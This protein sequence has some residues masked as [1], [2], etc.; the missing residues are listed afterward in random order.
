MLH[1]ASFRGRSLILGGVVKY[2]AFSELT[3]SHNKFCS[4]HIE[5]E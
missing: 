5:N 3:A 4:F 1:L 2:N